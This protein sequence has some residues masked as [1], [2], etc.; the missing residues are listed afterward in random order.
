MGKSDYHELAQ[1]LSNPEI[2]EEVRQVL[3]DI[4]DVASEAKPVEGAEE[5]A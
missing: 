3:D 1:H 2:S 5:Y 4:C